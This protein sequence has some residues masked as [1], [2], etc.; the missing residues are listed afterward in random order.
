[1]LTHS[2]FG[3]TEFGGERSVKLIHEVVFDHQWQDFKITE[4]VDAKFAVNE[5]CK[6]VEEDKLAETLQYTGDRMIYI[7]WSFL[8]SVDSVLGITYRTRLRNF[9]FP[10]QRNMQCTKLLAENYSIR[11]I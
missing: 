1:M 9:F 3:S 8:C 6:T 7:A 2:V 10:M 11:K 4:A 5:K